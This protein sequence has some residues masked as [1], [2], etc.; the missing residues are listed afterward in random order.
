[1]LRRLEEA[2]YQGPVMA[3]PLAGCRSLK[4]LTAEETAFRVAA[5]LQS[6]WPRGTQFHDRHKGSSSLSG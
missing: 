5:A 6:V 2:G 4:G 1:M 3:E